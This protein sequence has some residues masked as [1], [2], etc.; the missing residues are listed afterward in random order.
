MEI[1][2]W[3]YEMLVI[4]SLIFQLRNFFSDWCVDMKTEGILLTINSPQSMVLFRVSHEFLMVCKRWHQSQ[5]LN[6][7][8]FSLLHNSKY[9]LLK[10][11]DLHN[12]S[13]Y[14]CRPSINRILFFALKFILKICIIHRSCSTFTLPLFF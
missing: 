3:Y 10:I 9:F 7:D 14:L 6:I 11:F 12:L 4:P 8:F 2:V 13:P 5:N 1:I